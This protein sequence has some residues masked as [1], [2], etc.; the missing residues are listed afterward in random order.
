[1]LVCTFLLGCTSKDSLQI[2]GTIPGDCADEVDND[3]NGQKDCDDPGCQ[4]Y[5]ECQNNADSDDADSDGFSFVDGDCND[6]DSNIHPDAAEICDGQDNDCDGLVDDDDS[7]LSFEDYT[8]SELAQFTWYPDLDEDSFGDSN[9]EMYSCSLPE[10][11][12]IYVSNDTDCDDSNAAIHPNAI[13]ICDENDT[14]EDCNDLS[15]DEDPNVDA[16]S[17][18]DY[19]ADSDADNFGDENDLVQQC[20]MP[21]GYIIDSSDCNDLDEN[22]H[23]EAT[24]ICDENDVDEDCNGSADDEDPNVD[25]SSHL[26]FYA[27][28]DEDGFGDPDTVQSQCEMP[29]GYILDSSDCD[30][31]EV[32]IHPDATEVCD[33]GVD[34]NCNG[35]ADDLDSSVD[36]TTFT[37]FFAD[38]DVDGF[39]DANNSVDGCELPSGMVTDDTDCDDSNDDINPSA[40]EICDE[41]N[42]DEDCNDLVEDDDPNVDTTSHMEFF[43]DEDDDGFGDPDVS[44]EMC[45]IPEGYILDATDCDDTD[46]NIHPDAIEVCDELN[47]DEDCNDLIDDDD[48]NVDPTSHIS[49]Y[50]D[51]DLD[52][53]GDVDVVLLQCETPVGYTLDA[54]DCDD[55][56]ENINPDATEICDENEVDEDCDS[57][58][59]DADSDVEGLITF[60]ADTDNDDHGNSN[61]TLD[62]CE[63]PDGYVEIAQD[64][65]DNDATIHENALELCDG[66]DNDC[67]GSLD[68]GVTETYYLDVDNDGYGAGVGYEHCSDPSGSGQ[69]FT[70]N[71]DDCN[72]SNSEIYPFAKEHK[73]DAVD[74]NCD[75][76]EDLSI[77]CQSF[78]IRELLDP[79]EATDEL[80][81]AIFLEV[82]SQF[83]LVYCDADVTYEESKNHC[84]SAGYEGLLTLNDINRAASFKTEFDAL[85]K[86]PLLN[87]FAYK[88]LWLG[89]TS[90]ADMNAQF[91]A[92]EWTWDDGVISN[93]EE[94][95]ESSEPNGMGSEECVVAQYT[96]SDIG[97]KWADRDCNEQHSFV[98]MITDDADGDGISSLEVGGD[99]CDDSDYFTATGIA[100]NETDPTA[101]MEDADGDG[102]GNANPIHPDV[103][104][105]TDCDDS[106][107]SIHPNVAFLEADPTACMEDQD[108]DGYGNTNPTNPDVV[109]GSDCN[110]EARKTR[111]GIATNE[112]DASACMEDI[113]GDGYGNREPSHPETVAG[114]DC[115]DKDA[116]VALTCTDVDL[117]GIYVENDCDDTNANV[118]ASCTDADNDGFWA[119]DN[120]CDDANV[121]VALSC[122]DI[123][124]DGFYAEDQDCDDDNANVAA[125]CTDEDGDGF[126]LEGIDCND[127]DPLLV[128]NCTDADGD[129]YYA[130]YDDCD[131]DNANVA[132]SCTDADGDGHYLEDND[133]DDTVADVSGT[134]TDEDGDGFYAESDDCDDSNAN[135]AAS[136]TD[137][138]G[139][140][141]YAEDTDCDDSDPM[142]YPGVATLEADS[143]ACMVDGDGDG[144]GD[145]DPN[146]P[147]VVPG[148]D[149]ADEDASILM[150]SMY[151]DGDGDGYGAGNYGDMVEVCDPDED[152]D[153]NGPDSAFAF[154]DC[155]DT[156][157]DIHPYAE[158]IAGDG[159]DSNCDGLEEMD[160]LELSCESSAPP[161]ED[162]YYV[163]CGL[164]DVDQNPVVL[165]QEEFNT[166]CTDTKLYHGLASVESDD[167]VELLKEIC[168]A[169]CLTGLKS[170]MYDHTGA[171]YYLPTEV[172][173]WWNEINPDFVNLGYMEFT[174][175]G[176]DQVNAMMYNATYGTSPMSIVGYIENIGQFRYMI[177]E[178]YM[179]MLEDSSGYSGTY[180]INSF[181]CSAHFT[182]INDPSNPNTW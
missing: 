89:L 41:L 48:P 118:A 49:F 126:Y 69:T 67:D 51:A 130:D 84:T 105:G 99:D 91:F 134:C 4:S 108:V 131:D 63:M 57:Y 129:G 7:D 17:F 95:W 136:C 44:Q 42:V 178:E 35:L 56:D 30:D 164:Y 174:N 62:K 97:G 151:E 25:A 128:Q 10:E 9:V 121:N 79:I 181:S 172:Y 162:T 111:P 83:Y 68:E 58:S 127:N 179:A 81:N 22:I 18:I 158:E 169:G 70:T 159:E 72:D 74:S 39:G 75:G 45:E 117:D 157:K 90:T 156:D 14:D 86:P 21:D 180:S 147:D 167:E 138:D 54:M 161:L 170:E 176:E 132:A 137:T 103:V 19:F 171:G 141:H 93:N 65:D 26:T 32:N 94:F 20:E 59:D 52:G 34:N 85:F 92:Y 122:T 165:T 140:G 87:G 76:I 64:C 73:M 96:S 149:C 88:D 98:C 16:S 154:G 119:E 139:D 37:T 47:V 144:Y 114:T 123:D 107:F 166:R 80:G 143:T 40:T 12:V 50:A 110:D 2:E 60:Y 160:G 29:D 116:T 113:D 106:S 1:M 5:W 142:A 15:D 24:E 23:P 124:E 175:T 173:S 146:H 71:S 177:H 28:I 6:H 109:V 33:S 102:Y 152:S 104:A 31:A 13:E 148:N 43:A 77:N 46:G 53:F 163:A 36:S 38:L 11:E 8:S 125:S 182:S 135:V 66:L 155:D 115:D 133:C 78:V 27:D 61:D 153:G 55:T 120:D 150:Y 82:E 145:N 101:C 168:P 3:E 112:V 100:Y